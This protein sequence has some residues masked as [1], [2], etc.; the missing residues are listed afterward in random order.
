MD[1]ARQWHGV[2]THSGQRRPSYDGGDP[3]SDLIQTCSLRWEHGQTGERSC[4]RSPSPLSEIIFH[5]KHPY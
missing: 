3:D 2:G 1:L 4:G 5:L